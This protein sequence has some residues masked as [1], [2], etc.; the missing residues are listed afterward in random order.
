MSSDL[1]PN[2]EHPPNTPPA[3]GQILSPPEGPT[4][5]ADA[6]PP[7]SPS[8]VLHEF[9]YSEFHAGPFPHP[10]YLER[11]AKSYTEAPAMI[12]TNFQEQ[13]RHRRDIEDKVIDSRILLASRGQWIGAAIGMTGVVGSLI[14]IC[15]GHDWAGVSFGSIVLLG[16]VGVFVTGRYKDM[17]E[18][19][20]KEKIRERIKRGDSVEKLEGP[21]PPGDR[22]GKSSAS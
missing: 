10:L 14:A 18:R 20:E 5:T 6:I 11:M 13:S 16:L 15:L 17:Q 8:V 3:E 21:Q 12:F 1:V 19:L 7:P 22:P 9:E 2:D 4:F